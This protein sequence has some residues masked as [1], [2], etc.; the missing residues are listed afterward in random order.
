MDEELSRSRIREEIRSWL[1]NNPHVQ[2]P[3][4]LEHL[5]RVRSVP[6]EVVQAATPVILEEFHALVVSSVL[7]IGY[8]DNYETPW[9][10]LTTYGRSALETDEAPPAY[11][12][13]AYIDHVRATV[14]TVPEVALFYLGEAVGTFNLGRNLAAAV[15]LGVA[16]EAIL[17]RLIGAFAQSSDARNG[18]ELGRSLDREAISRT[19]DKFRR[20]FDAA[21]VPPDLQRDLDV[22]LGNVFNFIRMTRN[23][24]GHPTGLAVERSVLESQLRAFEGFAKRLCALADFFDARSSA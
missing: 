21:T 24:A 12:P 11:D 16:A 15:M 4:F 1:P 18:D 7:R 17:V 22:Y 8:G 2:V 3:T 9:M 13:D 10:T 5:R 19:Y 14:S 6:N 23:E 20:Q